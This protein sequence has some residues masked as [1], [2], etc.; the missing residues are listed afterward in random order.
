M[1]RRQESVD[2]GD[3]SYINNEE[4]TITLMSISK[5][6]VIKQIL[7]V[8]NPILTRCDNLSLSEVPESDANSSYKFG[9]END[10][11]VDL[12]KMKM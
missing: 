1:A 11:Y 5:Y 8:L 4:D 6:I 12:D 10:D 7:Q 3:A 2:D 9:P